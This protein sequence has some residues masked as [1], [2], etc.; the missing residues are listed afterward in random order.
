MPGGCRIHPHPL[1]SPASSALARPRPARWS[2][3]PSEGDPARD[4]GEHGK[5]EAGARSG[6]AARLAVKPVHDGRHQLRHQHLGGVLVG[7]V[8][9]VRHV[10]QGVRAVRH[11][12]RDIWGVVVEHAVHHQTHVV[13]DVFHVR[14]ALVRRV[15]VRG[16]H[17]SQGV[18]GLCRVRVRQLGGVDSEELVP[19][20]D[21]VRHSVEGQRHG[22]RHLLGIPDVP[23]LDALADARGL[24][25]ERPNLVLHVVQEPREPHQVL[26]VV[27]RV[28]GVRT[29]DEVVRLVLDGLLH[30]RGGASDL[31][32]DGLQAL[33]ELGVVGGAVEDHGVVCHAADRVLHLGEGVVGDVEQLQDFLARKKGRRLLCGAAELIGLRPELRRELS[34]G[35]VALLPVRPLQLP[36]LLDRPGGLPELLLRQ[37]LLVGLHLLLLPRPHPRHVLRLPRLGLPVQGGLGV[38]LALLHPPDLLVQ[39]GEL[40]FLVP[41]LLLR[42]P[43]RVGQQALRGGALLQHRIGDVG[44]LP[45]LQRRPLHLEHG[46]VVQGLELAVGTGL[47]AGRRLRLLGLLERLLRGGLGLGRLG[48][49]PLAVALQLERRVRRGLDLRDVAADRPELRLVRRLARLALQR[50]PAAHAQ[51]RAQLKAPPHHADPHALT[52][53]N[54]WYKRDMQNP[55]RQT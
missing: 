1:S 18:A 2:T 23:A 24:V 47:V 54:V 16:E 38:E 26:L 19:E 48:A 53:K 3:C 36:L 39:L 25:V 6:A 28:S 14:Q 49:E 4:R 31:E 51:E 43:L 22:Q 10:Q 27:V 5:G 46:A 33:R 8:L 52:G 40:P 29:V 44:Q 32:A 7:E 45:V 42:L 11:R 12:R 17:V 21:V 30:R 35:R 15:Y 20:L 37:P 55:C 41:L 50:Q 13:K 9:R 34:L